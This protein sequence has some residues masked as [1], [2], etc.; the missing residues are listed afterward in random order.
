MK[1]PHKLFVERMQKQYPVELHDALEKLERKKK[2]KWGELTD[3]K[4]QGFTFGF[5]GGDD[6]GDE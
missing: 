1:D 5:G 2:T 6:S 3:I 4:G